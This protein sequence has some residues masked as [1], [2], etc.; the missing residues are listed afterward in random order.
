[1]KFKYKI[2]FLSLVLC[3]AIVLS[4][5]DKSR[6]G[7]DEEIKETITSGRITMLVDNTVQP[8]AEDV[9]A[10]FHSVYDRAHITQ[11]NMNEKEIIEGLKNG[12]AR[13]AVM[14]REL[15]EQESQYFRERKI[16]PEVTKFATDAIALITNNRS[17][18][19][20]MELEEVIKVIQGKESKIKR[21]VFDNVNS[22]TIQY[23]LKLAN[24]TSMPEKAVYSVNSTEEVF[25]YI[26]DNAGAI[27]IVGVNWLVQTPPSLTK[28]VENVRVLGLDNVKANSAEKKYYKP[29][30]SNIGAGLY[31]LTR[32]LY[33]LNYQGKNGLGMGFAT[34]ISAFEGQRII[35]KSGLLPV[36][37]PYREI[38][39]RNEL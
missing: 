29:S 32:S 24:V 20:V 9:L 33:V 34:Y 37:I 26:N 22:S 23:L 4:C 17:A 2:A 28:Y 19:T 8:I 30:Q 7:D 11:V 1:M 36:E 38:Q 6:A 13:I 35:L 3:F 27:G 15:T 25:K 31:P 5:K 21:L 16:T 10:V 12:T 14:P 39:V 18:D